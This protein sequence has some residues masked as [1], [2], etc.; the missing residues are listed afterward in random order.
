MRFANRVVMVTGAGHGIG[1]AVA[2][3]FGAEGA[4]V[5]VNDLNEGRANEVARAMQGGAIGVAADVSSK[6]Q[7]DAM[8]DAVLARLG[9]AGGVVNNAGTIYAGRQFLQVDEQ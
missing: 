3:R 8:I 2:E 6:G 1:R 4:R 7:G 9:A 5:V